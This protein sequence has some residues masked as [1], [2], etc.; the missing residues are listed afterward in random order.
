MEQTIPIIGVSEK[1]I[2]EQNVALEQTFWRN[3][4]L[5]AGTFPDFEGLEE[6]KYSEMG[7]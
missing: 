3:V 2:S 1:W 4:R 7:I 6:L 5:W